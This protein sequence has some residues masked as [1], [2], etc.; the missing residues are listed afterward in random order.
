MTSDDLIAR[1]AQYQVREA[2]PPGTVSPENLT[3]SGRST[4]PHATSREPI[5]NR[6]PSRRTND[7]A[8]RT[9]PPPISN[10]TVYTNAHRD[11]S[12]SQLPTPIHAQP[13]SHPDLSDESSLPPRTITPPT[14]LSFAIT[15]DCSDHSSDEEEESSAATIADRLRRDHLP[16]PPSMDSSSDSTEDGDLNRWA[17]PRARTAT[18]H[19]RDRRRAIP[20]RIE[21]AAPSAAEEARNGPDGRPPVEVLAPHAR[22]FIEREKSM[23]SIKFEPLV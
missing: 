7:A 4:T 11:L 17:T 3:H 14:P 13:F 19:R 1:T 8:V 21:V 5:D 12:S 18:R 10:T 15:T 23:I 6:P 20:S 22:F 9:I 2:S 16:L